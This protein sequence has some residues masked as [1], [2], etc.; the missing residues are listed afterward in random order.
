M[1]N[2]KKSDC[3]FIQKEW[4]ADNKLPACSLRSAFMNYLDITTPL[5]QNMLNLLLNHNMNE[6]DRTNIK[7]LTTVR[8]VIHY[9][10]Q[11]YFHYS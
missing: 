1:I 6:I 9:L 7:K 3:Q 5:S 2:N 10:K 4:I 11:I 8:L